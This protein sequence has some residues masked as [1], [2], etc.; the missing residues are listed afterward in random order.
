MTNI[1]FISRASNPNSGGMERL[2]YEL[3]D[4]VSKDKRVTTKS[5]IHK[6]GRTTSPF[7]IFTIIP[8]ALKEAR[9]A[10]VVHL[11]DPMLSFVGWLVKLLY[12]K[13]VAVTVHGLDITYS[14]PLYQLYLALFFKNFNLYLPISDHVRKLLTKKHSVSGR[15]NIINPGIHDNF[16]DPTISRSDLAELLNLP[17]TDKT[18]L[19]TSGRLVKRKGHAWFITNILKELPPDYLYAIAGDGPAKQDILAAAKRNNTTNQIILLGRVSN[20]QLKILYN[21]IDAFIQPNISVNNDVEGF[22]L[23]LLEATLC[24]RPVFAAAIEGMTDAIKNK[25][26]GTL[27]PP[28]NI[29]EWTSVLFKFSQVPTARQYTLDN[30]S[31]TD[32][33]NQ[34]ILELAN[35]T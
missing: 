10:D 31:W 26:N 34:F 15:I 30:F 33:K 22:G 12:K 14:N 16:Y 19:F 17:L 27:L 29:N 3:I 35:L 13:P 25:K 20:R 21:T 8:R 6:G 11:G 23:V 7:F 5:L 18:V 32:K 2:S 28:Q 9:H 4:A 1:L 24:N